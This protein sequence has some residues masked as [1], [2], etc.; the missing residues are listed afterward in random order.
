M[1]RSIKPQ[2]VPHWHR[3]TSFVSTHAK[4]YA[5]NKREML[6]RFRIYKRNAKIAAMWQELDEGTAVYG[7]TVFSDLSPSEF[8]RI[9]TPYRWQDPEHPIREVGVHDLER[10]LG[11][12]E[13]GGEVP[14][15][16]DWRQ[17]GMVTEV[18]NQGQC[19]SCWAFS[20]T[21]NVEGQWAM[22]TGKLVSLSE[23]ELVDCDKVDQG[24]NGG[25]PANAYK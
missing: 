14:E 25:L 13:G 19:G 2:D 12:G 10:L 4:S 23:Q 16:W 22:K 18:K 3:F 6:R 24:C 1:P 11:S 9:Y 7:E 21:G 8:R 20:V 5:G 17:K 15:E